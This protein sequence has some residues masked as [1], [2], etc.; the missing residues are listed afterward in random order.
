ACE[1]IPHARLIELPADVGE[2]GDITDFFVRLGRSSEDFL[3]LLDQAMPVPPAPPRSVPS[4]SPWTQ[5]DE[6]LPRERI[7]RIKSDLPIAKVIERYVKLQAV[8]DRFV[9]LCPFHEDR[10]PSFTVFLATQTFYCFG[11]RK[12]GD[13]ITFLR[14]I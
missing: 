9:G 11:C 7:D 1:L 2:S 5:G 12:H 4:F 6:S 3:G 14:E 10:N 8:G 13:V